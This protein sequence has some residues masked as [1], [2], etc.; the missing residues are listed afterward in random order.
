MLFALALAAAAQPALAPSPQTRA[1]QTTAPTAVVRQTSGQS[2]LDELLRSGQGSQGITLGGNYTVG[3]AGTALRAQRTHAPGV[4][5]VF[6]DDP[7][8]GWQES[9]LVGIPKT[10][11]SANPP[12]LVMFHGADVSEWDCYINTTLFQDALDRG[13]Y[14]IAPLGAHQVHYGI[15][16]AQTNV[17]YALDLFTSLIPEDPSRVYGIGFSMGGGAV[18]SYAARHLDPDHPRFAAVVNHTGTVSV[19]H[20]YYS[21]ADT[22]IFDHPDTFGGSPAQFPFLYSRS[23]TVDI[24]EF[25]DTVDPLTDMARNLAHVPVLNEHAVGDPLTYIVTQTQVVYAWLLA[26]PGMETHLLTP[27]FDVHAWSTIDENTALNYLLSKTLVVPAEGEHRIL[28]DREAAWHHFYIYQDAPGAYTPLRWVMDTAQNRLTIDETEN[29][30]RVV[31]DTLSIGLNTA[32]NMDVQLGTA[33]GTAE[34]VTLEGY[35]LAPQEVLRDGV[36]TVNYTWDAVTQT[37]TLHESDASGSPVWRVR[38]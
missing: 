37:V 29:C 34:E 26:L 3:N 11:E 33:D 1:P 14:V 22:F 20:T 32:V 4:W 35:R 5:Q 9:M 8:T 12:L 36:P 23:S 25:N 17:E 19:A 21:V 31:V 6:L 18:M 30:A 7:G 38:P 16:Y 24:D 2:P 10:K 28:A 27:P 15:P 13:W